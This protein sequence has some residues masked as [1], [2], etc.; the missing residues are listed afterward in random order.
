MTDSMK[1][2]WSV[3]EAVEPVLTPDGWR[4][5]SQA[6]REALV[7]AKLVIPGAAAER[8]R[9]PVCAEA[10]FER[11]IA[12]PSPD[13][14]QRF[15]IKC[16][17]EMR[18]PISAADRQTWRVD[19]AAVASAVSVALG[20]EG[21]VK[22]MGNDRV[23]HCGQHAWR[24][25]RVE[26][27]LARGLRRKDAVQV[28]GII[29]RG[30][31]PPIVFVPC[32]HP[33]DASWPDPPP[34]VILLNSAAR[35]E[36]GR[37]TIDGRQ[38]DQVLMRRTRGDMLPN[39]VFRCRGDYWEVAFDG[40]EVKLLKDSVGMRYLSRLLVEP[41]HSIAAVTLLAARAGID[42]RA[43]AG[44]SGEMLDDVGKADL[45]TKYVEL[46]A[47]RD[48]A[49]KFNDK[50]LDQINEQLDALGVELSRRLGVGGR[51]REE[52]DAERCR[53]SVSMAVSREIEKINKE[54]P[55]LGTHLMTA[56]SS[57][58][59]FKYAPDRDVDWLL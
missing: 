44:T 50:R 23:Y 10:H 35:F 29:P 21:I 43:A 37:L 32:E 54:L 18:V 4:R 11:V 14:T 56:V 47:Q 5:I 31:I 15:F 41:K 42:P 39:N 25:L 24:D 20:M 30:I 22:S 12:R 34:T 16:P 45:R 51:A 19:V 17:K 40:S 27:Y 52:S 2:L 33:A 59:I 38:I 55:P 36:A 9:C 6:T 48:E 28:A 57:G 58:A 7:S 3:M 49:E 26:V 46:M 13:G 53:K 8:V 1:A